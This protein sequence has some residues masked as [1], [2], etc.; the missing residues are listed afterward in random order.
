MSIPGRA[1]GRLGDDFVCPPRQGESIWL[2]PARRVWL[3]ADPRRYRR[4]AVWGHAAGSRSVWTRSVWRRDALS[5][6]PRSRFRA[7]VLALVAVA[8]I[9]FLTLAA[10]AVFVWR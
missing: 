5:A 3:M 1:H 9:T 10:Y 8:A 7:K 6:K 4:R 2:N